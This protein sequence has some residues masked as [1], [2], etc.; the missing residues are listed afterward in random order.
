[1]LAVAVVPA[2][3]QVESVVECGRADSTCGSAVGRVLQ[4]PGRTALQRP[5]RG[6]GTGDHVHD[7][8]I[9]C[10]P[11]RSA[12]GQ[13]LRPQ[14]FHQPV[15]LGHAEARQR[16]QCRTAVAGHGVESHSVILTARGVDPCAESARAR[17]HLD[18]RL[19]VEIKAPQSSVDGRG[20]GGC[21]HRRCR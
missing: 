7:Y 11:D 19:V 17:V 20:S 3:V 13:G 21:R 6:V 4:E 18:V 15:L 8:H 2:L 14:Y 10:V 5:R 16:S 12:L 9:E 1:M